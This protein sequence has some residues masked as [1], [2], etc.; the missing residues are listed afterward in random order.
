M[1]GPITI[2]PG[3]ASAWSRAATFGRVWIALN[4]RWASDPTL[5]IT[6]EP[7]FRPIRNLGHPPGP[8]EVL[9]PVL[10]G[11]R[12]ASP[13]QGVVGLVPAGVEDRDETVAG[14]PLDSPRRRDRG[15]DDRPVGVEHLED[16]WPRDPR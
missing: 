1:T 10:D 16:L 6:A 8:A 13:A 5:P 7:V 2:P 14:E 3:V 4:E 15:D 12:R 9:G 11:H